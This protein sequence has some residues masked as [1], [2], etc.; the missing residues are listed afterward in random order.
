M[1]R[2]PP[3]STLFPYTAL[4][5]SNSKQFNKSIEFFTAS[6]VP[7]TPRA[8]HAAVTLDDANGTVLQIGGRRQV[9]HG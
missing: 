7:T 9:D 2:L 3:R 4:F 1:I 6:G 8:E 5:R